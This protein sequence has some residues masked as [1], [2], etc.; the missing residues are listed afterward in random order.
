M[1]SPV[2]EIEML[3]T[4]PYPIS[5][6]NPSLRLKDYNY[7]VGERGRGDL[8][9]TVI[10]KQLRFWK[11]ES[12]LVACFCEGRKDMV[13]VFKVGNYNITATVGKERVLF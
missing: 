10:T 7:V 9:V 4:K 11:A 2:K 1:F 6:E 3:C 13:R 5:F 12:R 8:L